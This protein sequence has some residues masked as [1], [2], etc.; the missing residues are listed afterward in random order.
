MEAARHIAETALSTPKI[1][2]SV[3]NAAKV[4]KA[5]GGWLVGFDAYN[6]HAT[7]VAY[8]KFWNVA[9]ASVTVASDAAL[10][11]FCVPPASAR[12]FRFDPPLKIETAM[13]YAAT[14]ENVA[15]GTAPT[16]AI[17]ATILFV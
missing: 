1:D 11:A 10:F 17:T 2:D 7:D 13:S 12:Y 14:Q 3:T 6:G 9:A 4:L 5:T 15:G 8:L 16:T